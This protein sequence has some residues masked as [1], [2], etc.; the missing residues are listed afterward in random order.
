VLWHRGGVTAPLAGIE[1]LLVDLD[2]V[3]YVDDEP[4]TGAREAVVRL[5]AAGLALRFVTNTTRIRGRLTELLPLS[6]RRDRRLGLALRR[7]RLA[8]GR[9]A[10]RHRPGRPAQPP[11]ILPN[12][13][14]LKGRYRSRPGS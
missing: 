13:C 5:R 9:V 2:G 8:L 1:A 6:H 14:H 4:V 12:R 11:R 7:R 3:L 10:V